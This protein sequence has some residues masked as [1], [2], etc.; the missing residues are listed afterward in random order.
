MKSPST[1]T[2]IKIKGVNTFMSIDLLVYFE[3]TKNTRS[4][5]RCKER[6]SLFDIRRTEV[7][8]SFPYF[9]SLEKRLYQQTK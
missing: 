3:P 2:A 1:N 4:N 5:H 7:V 8:A 9:E 6:R